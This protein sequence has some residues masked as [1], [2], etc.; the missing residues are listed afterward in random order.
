MIC[1]ARIY[2]YQFIINIIIIID[3]YDINAFQ[4]V[5]V[6]IQ[7]IVI[8][9]LFLLES[10]KPAKQK[11]SRFLRKFITE[12][13]SRKFITADPFGESRHTAQKNSRWAPK[14][15]LISILLLV[16]L[17]TTGFEGDYMLEDNGSREEKEKTKD[18]KR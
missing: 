9:N 10:S 6:A 1:I 14:I 4:K 12:D 11:F 13:L 8:I 7:R 16:S 17:K 5:T 18:E 15:A 3:D 2:Y